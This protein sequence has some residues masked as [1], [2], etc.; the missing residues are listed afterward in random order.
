MS[1]GENPGS[2]LRFLTFFVNTIRAVYEHADL[3]RA[4]VASAGNDHRLGANEA[5]P[6]IISVFVGKVLGDVLERIEKGETTRDD[7]REIV[8]LLSKIP[9]L[10]LDNTD[11]NRT[12]PFAFTGN[13]F[14]IRMVGSNQSCAASMTAMNTMMAEQLSK[15]WVSYNE[16]VSNGMDRD[17]AILSILQGYIAEM[18]PILFEGDNYSDEWKDEAKMRGLSN[19]PNTPDALDAYVSERTMKLFFRQRRFEPKGVTG[20]P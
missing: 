14:E 2:N 15:F 3:L 16:C 5:P 18:R 1:P 7:V 10:K 19:S 20:T 8:D 11:R 4:S 6:A 17:L 9:D 12:S 13:K